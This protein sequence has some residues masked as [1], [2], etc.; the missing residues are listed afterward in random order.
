MVD[1]S[2][3]TRQQMMED[4]CETLEDHLAAGCECDEEDGD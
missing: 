4:L 2:L 3:M 1:R